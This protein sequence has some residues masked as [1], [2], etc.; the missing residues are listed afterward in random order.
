VTGGEL[1]DDAKVALAEL[2]LTEEQIDMVANMQG[3]WAGGRQGGPPGGEGRA[4]PGGN[5]GGMPGGMPGGNN[6]PPGMGGPG[7]GNGGGATA[8]AGFDA[9]YAVVMAALLLILAGATALVARPR[10]GVV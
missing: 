9:G 10:K 3:R 5:E 7:W 2:G 1:T 6:A 4:F 8:P